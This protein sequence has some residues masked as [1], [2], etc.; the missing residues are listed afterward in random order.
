[1]ELSLFDRRKG[2]AR[3]A[4]SAVL[5][6]VLLAGCAV[7]DERVEEHRSPIIGGTTVSVGQYPTVVAILN[8]SLCTGTLVAPDLVLT[9]AHCVTPSVLGYSSQSQVTAATS[10][11]VDT[12]NVY[13][14]SGR[15]ISASETIPNPYFD[16]DNLGD[17]DIGLVRLSQSVTDRTPSVINRLHNDAMP[18]LTTTLIGYGLT[19]PY[20]DNSA[21]RLYV[22]ANKSSIACTSD[23]GS[24][25]NLLCY[26][27][28]DG[29]GSC[30]GDSGGPSFAT[31]G[32][33]Q[34]VVGVTSFGDRYCQQYGAYTRTDA[35]LSFLDQ[36]APELK[37]VSDGACVAECG[38][39][40]L[41]ADPDCADCVS[42]GVC[43]DGCGSGGLP[44]D[45]DC[46]TC[47]SDGVC[48]AECGT[49]GWPVD[50]DCPS[51]VENEDCGDPSLRCVDGSCVGIPPDAGDLGD[52]C[53]GNADCASGICADGPDGKRCIEYC[54]P[55]AS[56]CP[57]GFDCLPA[58]TTGACWPGASL[59]GDDSMVTGG[60]SAGERGSSSSGLLL[61]GLFAVLALRRRSHD[62][63]R[64]AR[65]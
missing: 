7:S 53:D 55:S 22:L 24:D 28:S 43:E 31:I 33:A 36:N 4:G 1:M 41:P 27:Q 23:L 13:G 62:R 18:G 39:G 6:A 44:A 42:D 32:G 2:L 59:F 8:N 45:P 29:T 30:S 3:W 63:G 21:G 54:D 49:G 40:G 20:D 9:A 14:T 10:V 58:G 26:T 5:I 51:C 50:P 16:I 17:N 56:S 47:V 34:K 65:S 38:S 12:T 52:T 61:I 35:E 11:I 48:V 25:A 46:P 64:S 19:D 37:C 60:C 15:E 57:S